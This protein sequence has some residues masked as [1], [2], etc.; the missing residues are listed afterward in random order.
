VDVAIDPERRLVRGGARL[1]VGDRRYPD[2]AAFMTLA[3]RFDRDELR[4]FARKRVQEFGE[5]GVAVEAIEGDGGACVKVSKSRGARPAAR[6][7]M[8][9]PGILAAFPFR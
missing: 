3:D 7:C 9:R 5:F 1:P 4:V 8:E 6:S 2:V